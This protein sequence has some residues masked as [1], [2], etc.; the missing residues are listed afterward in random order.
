[1]GF[2]GWGLQG[3]MGMDGERVTENSHSKADDGTE[4]EHVRV[5]QELRKSQSSSKPMRM[6]KL[7]TPQVSGI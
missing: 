1:M 5:F 6:N 4:R 2:H 7:I 3:H